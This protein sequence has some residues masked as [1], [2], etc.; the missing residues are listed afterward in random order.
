MQDCGL[1]CIAAGI[2]VT[3]FCRDLLMEHWRTSYD[4]S[5][6]AD[7][8]VFTEAD[9]C[10]RSFLRQQHPEVPLYERTPYAHDWTRMRTVG[11][12]G[13]STLFV[14]MCSEKG[15]RNKTD[16]MSFCIASDACWG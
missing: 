7:T 10:A 12:E 16:S 2:G 8:A 11:R 1:V 3:K 4:I 13:G 5:I 15:P 6:N 9:P 14:Q